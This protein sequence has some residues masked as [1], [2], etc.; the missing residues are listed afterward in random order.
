MTK[1]TIPTQEEYDNAK[2]DETRRSM[3]FPLAA[4]GPDLIRE[5]LAAHAMSSL[6]SIQHIG[7]GRR[8]IFTLHQRAE[9]SHAGKPPNY[10]KAFGVRT[11][12]YAE[13]GNGKRR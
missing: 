4:L 12:G 1:S 3:G 11:K 5:A 2:R 6:H 13:H 8:T 10:V 9:R 7:A